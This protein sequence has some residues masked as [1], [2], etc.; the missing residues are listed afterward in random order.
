MDDLA[1]LHEASILH[2]IELRFRMDKIYT[3]SGPILIAMNPFK[4]LPIYGEEI[5]KSYHNRP[6]GSLEPHCYNEAEAAF[7]NMVKTRQNQS[8]V[9]CGESGAGKTETTKLML[10]YLSVISLLKQG[11][12]A[13]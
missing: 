11:G 10:Q 13:G 4:W 3:N 2:N 1:T 12:D 5:I 6:Y 9:I 7:Q 8:V